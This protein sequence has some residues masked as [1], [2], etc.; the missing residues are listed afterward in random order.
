M[1]MRMC[2]EEK[3]FQKDLERLR[4]R[5]K[6]DEGK[7]PELPQIADAKDGKDGVLESVEKNISW[8]LDHPMLD[9][10]AHQRIKMKMWKEG[11]EKEELKTPVY[12]SVPAAPHR[13]PP[14]A[15]G[16][17]LMVASLPLSPSPLPSDVVVQLKKWKM[18]QDIKLY[19]YSH[20]AIEAQKLFLSNTNHGEL[21][22]IIDNHYDTTF[23]KK[24]DPQSFERLVKELGVAPEDVLFLT[25]NVAE[26]KAAQSVGLGVVLVLTHRRNIERLSAEDR[27]GF[28]SRIIRSFNELELDDAAPQPSQSAAQDMPPSDAA[29]APAESPPEAQTGATGE[30]ATSPSVDP[31]IHVQPPASTTEA[32][33]SASGPSGP[34]DAAPA[35]AP[36][37]GASQPDQTG[38]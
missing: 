2:R 23:G 21:E 10:S 35:P 5:V 36:A 22:S 8:Y 25:K 19:V 26:A 15:S 30:P 11:Y 9:T 31:A 27:Q 38:Q 32:P 12:R 13:A 1:S 7:D 37:P 29:E 16:A 20:A 14:P 24:E 3:D 17:R 4:A 34:S 28:R 33:Q 18:E 6:K